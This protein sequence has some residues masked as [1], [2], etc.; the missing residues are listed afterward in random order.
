MNLNIVIHFLYNFKKWSSHLLL[1]HWELK[2]KHARNHIC[3]WQNLNPY[4]IVLIIIDFC[5]AI[6]SFCISLMVLRIRQ[7]LC[8]NVP[9][10]GMFYH[11]KPVC[12]SGIKA[13]Y[14]H[15][16]R[17]AMTNISLGWLPYF[18]YWILHNLFC[19]DADISW[20]NFMLCGKFGGNFTSTEHCLLRDFYSVNKKTKIRYTV[21]L[22]K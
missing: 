18:D 6:T 12:D 5:D 19:Y 21:S 17:A 4:S 11:L 10:F 20:K 3:H 8:Y 15:K 22:K 14:R 7:I 1:C 16:T 13:L 9:S 2:E